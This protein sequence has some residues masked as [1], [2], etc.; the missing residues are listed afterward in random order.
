M[1]KNPVRTPLFF[2]RYCVLLR[3][4]DLLSLSYYSLTNRNLLLNMPNFWLTDVKPQTARPL[5]NVNN[6]TP[7]SR[8]GD[9]IPPMIQQLNWSRH[10]LSDWWHSQ[11]PS[12][13]LHWPDYVRVRVSVAVCL[14]GTVE[15]IISSGRRDFLVPVVVPRGAVPGRDSQLV[16][17]NSPP[18]CCPLSPPRLLFPL[19]LHSVNLLFPFE[20]ALLW[21]PHLLTLERREQGPRKGKES[22]VRIYSIVYRER[23]LERRS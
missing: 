9:W 11:N 22:P 14:C 7:C 12:A 10:P 13:S 15:V 5:Q 21:F 23:E 16:P 1:N 19:K 4:S 18:F 3:I 17:F 6:L 2:L 20:E 8:A